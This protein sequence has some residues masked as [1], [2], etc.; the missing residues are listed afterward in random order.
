MTANSTTKELESHA[1][2]YGL[3]IMVR[4]IGDKGC[5]Y[6]VIAADG[7]HLDQPKTMGRSIREAEEWIVAHAPKKKTK[8]KDMLN[9]LCITKGCRGRFA[10]KTQDKQYVQCPK[11]YFVMARNQDSK[12]ILLAQIIS[13]Q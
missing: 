1:R 6:V 13:S 2:R 12:Q 11:C 9:Q 3:N 5:L 8:Q 7:Y 10:L 4:K